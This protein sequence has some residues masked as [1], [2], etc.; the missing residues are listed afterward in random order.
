MARQIR[1]RHQ[2]DSDRQFTKKDAKSTKMEGRVARD[3][4]SEFS[5][6]NEVGVH[7]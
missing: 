1:L 5:T 7:E 2:N 3:L 6:H 4:D